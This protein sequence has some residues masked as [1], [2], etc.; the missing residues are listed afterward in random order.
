MWLDADLEP[1][2]PTLHLVSSPLE[3]PPLRLE[4]RL[5]LDLG[6]EAW[7]R[8]CSRVTSRLLAGAEVQGMVAPLA[9]LE[10]QGAPLLP[11][12]LPRGSATEPETPV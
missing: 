8:A 11:R 7:G 12:A 4:P 5:S 1:R 9:S 3:L 10:D 6:V 2:L